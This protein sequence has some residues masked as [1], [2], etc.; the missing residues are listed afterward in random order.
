[1]ILE[2]LQEFGHWYHEEDTKCICCFDFALG[3]SWDLSLSNSSKTTAKA[4]VAEAND[5]RLKE[6]V[7]G[8]ANGITTLEEVVVGEGNGIAALGELVA[9]IA[10]G[11]TTLEE[12]VAGIANGI[13]A[14]GELVAGIVPLFWGN[15]G[16]FW[17]WW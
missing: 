16:G 7:A 10:N 15:I 13:A 3:H 11:I 2:N 14:L 17:S 4:N 1:M 8:I 6:L 5:T 12:I 9:G